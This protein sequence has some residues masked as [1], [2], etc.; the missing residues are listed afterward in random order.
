MLTLLARRGPSDFAWP[1]RLARWSRALCAALLALLLAQP[2]AQAQDGQPLTLEER[3]KAAFI[4]KFLGYAD[5]PPAAFP[6]PMSP[7][8]IGVLGAD[9][10][11]EELA[12]I[13]AG[14]N[15]GNRPVVVRPLRES[16]LG[17]A[18]HLLFIAGHDCARDS[19]LAREAPNAL[20][21]VTDCASGT[22]AGSAINFRIID[23]R[24]RFDVAL[25][26]AEKNNVKLSSRL[27]TVANR[28]QKG[29]QP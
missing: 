7:I 6:G 13:V 2:A 18:M 28:V 25:E 20:L 14:R 8:T 27:L 21:V 11:A 15:I 24:V 22:P 5:F 3:V 4:Y 9:E 26:P 12:R 1:W 29:G 23:D 19:R 17:G 10:I 16:E